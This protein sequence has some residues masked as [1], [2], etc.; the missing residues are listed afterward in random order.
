MFVSQTLVGSWNE[1]LFLGFS[2]DSRLSNNAVMVSH[3][4]WSLPFSGEMILLC[5]AICMLKW[6]F[7]LNS[8][9]ICAVLYVKID[10]IHLSSCVIDGVFSK[11]YGV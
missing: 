6:K 5:I 4:T 11:Y 1:S 8:S 3:P 10:M 2:C 7:Y 9:S